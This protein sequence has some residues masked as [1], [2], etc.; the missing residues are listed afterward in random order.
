ML[1]VRR[2]TVR[3]GV[4]ETCQ[5]PPI[6]TTPTLSGVNLA[7]LY[8]PAPLLLFSSSWECTAGDIKMEGTR[9]KKKKK[10]KREAHCSAFS[11]FSFS[12]CSACWCFR[13][14]RSRWPGNQVG[15]P[16]GKPGGKPSAY[17]GRGGCS[18]VYR[19]LSQNGTLQGGCRGAKAATAEAST[20]RRQATR[21]PLPDIVSAGAPH[22]Y[23]MGLWFTGAF[24]RELCVT[25]RYS[26][27]SSGNI[28]MDL[29]C[30][31]DGDG[32]RCAILRGILGFFAPLGAINM[33]MDDTE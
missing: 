31:D 18:S 10:K 15:K 3:N 4:T 25:A 30:F 14:A 16:G 5:L 11:A 26:P 13:N 19:T 8:S 22:D 24:T 32:R 6:C 1:C 7:I 29:G 33:L 21:G 27:P 2:F 9:S 20:R 17:S 12:S 23:A 28:K